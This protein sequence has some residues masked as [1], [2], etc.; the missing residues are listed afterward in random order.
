MGKK[1]IN[2]VD[3]VAWL[4]TWENL[5]ANIA[6]LEAIT[7][8]KLQRTE[9][10]E[11]GA[12][13]CVD[14]S[15]GLEVVA[16]LPGNSPESEGLRGRLESHGEGVV[17]TVYGVENLE[18]HMRK[19]E[20]MGHPKGELM[21]GTR[22]DIWPDILLRERFGP[23][24]MGTW[25]VFSEID[26]DDHLIQ[27]VD[28]AGTNGASQKFINHVDHV[29]WVSKWENLD[30][31]I[32][33]L[34]A[35]TGARLGRFPSED[36]TRIVCVDWTTG[37]EVVAPMGEPCEAN[38]ALRGRLESHGEGVVAVIYGVENLEAHMNKLEAMGH[39]KGDLMGG[40]RGKP[41][42]EILL[43]ERFG[44]PIMGT[45]TVFSEID[46]DDGLISFVDVKEFAPAK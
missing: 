46:Y 18:E 27:F 11:Q 6:H 31:N 3:H 14:W 15:A 19:L 16:P 28:V 41:W 23:P 36:G 13:I 1:F 37:L 8:A 33:H 42:T 4:S 29:A 17:A 21:G 7:G 26:Y 45:W 25:T 44:P 5:D 32:A 38:A 9:K 34:E 10:P 22:D 24:I 2:H 43:R 40:E 30:A 39:P 35:I 12:I 20:A